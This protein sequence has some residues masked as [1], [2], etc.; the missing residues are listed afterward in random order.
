MK[1]LDVKIIADKANDEN[2]YLNIND[3][4]KVIK[5]A[6]EKGLYCVYV[7]IPEIT[8]DKLFSIIYRLNCLGYT[9]RKV[10]KTLT[11]SWM[12][13]N[14]EKIESELTNG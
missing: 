7:D 5:K 3:Y 6:S 1:A 9:V 4:L 8:F 12:N 13:P 10:A 11:I 2:D 14:D